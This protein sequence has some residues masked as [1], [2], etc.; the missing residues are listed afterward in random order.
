MN[1]F[2]LPLMATGFVRWVATEGSVGCVLWK[3]LGLWTRPGPAVSTLIDLLF[4]A[5]SVKWLSEDLLVKAMVREESRGGDKR[6]G[7]QWCFRGM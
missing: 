4:S 2:P 1:L 3:E 5:A 7:S 6:I